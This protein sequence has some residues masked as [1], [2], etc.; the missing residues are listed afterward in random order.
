MQSSMTLNT[1][2]A[3]FGAMIV[4]AFIPSVSVLTVSARAAASGFLHGVATTLGIILGDIIFI[5][6]AVLG[7]SLLADTMGHLFVWVKLIGGAYLLWLGFTL[8]QSKPSAEQTEAV[9]E[10]SLV[11][12]FFAGLFIT[13]A[14]Q[15]AIL[16]YW[17]F[18]PA[19]LDLSVISFVDTGIIILIA[20][21][22]IGFAKL[23]YAYAAIKASSLISSQ[24]YEGI[25]RLAG[26]IIMM[27]GMF[28][29]ATV[30]R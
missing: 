27:I 18:F 14:D 13:L 17:V 24:A 16:F 15:K 30:L 2:I 7:L 25:N 22:A 12:S 19:F 10:T 20:A 1:I 4:L 9:V 23:T 3:L 6:I 5:L 28:L 11:S 26:G 8:W 29:V 21:V